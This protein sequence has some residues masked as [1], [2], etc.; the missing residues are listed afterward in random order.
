MDACRQVVLQDYPPIWNPPIR[1]PTSC[2]CRP[3]SQS[4]KGSPY[5]GDD[6]P[7]IGVPDEHRHAGLV[8]TTAYRLNIC[9]P[10][11]R[12]AYPPCGVCSACNS[13]K[14]P[15]WD[16]KRAVWSLLSNP[17]LGMPET[18]YEIDLQNPSR[19]SDCGSSAVYVCGGSALS[20]RPWGYKMP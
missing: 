19:L 18:G 13:T 15:P 5:A 7:C 12:P 1:D 3:F 10:S 4:A 8:R 14:V 16:D 17:R 20:F 6:R 11:D 9:C 2:F